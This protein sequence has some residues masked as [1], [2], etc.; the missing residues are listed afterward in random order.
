MATHETVMIMMIIATSFLFGSIL[1]N[2]YI[3]QSITKAIVASGVGKW[4][5]MLFINIFLLVL[6]CFLP[7]VAII[8]IVNPVTH[9][10]ILAYG[11]DPIWFGVVV[12]I[13]MEVGLITPPVGLNLYIVQG[14]APDV[15]LS[16]VLLGSLPFAIILLLGIVIISIWP[17]LALWLPSK[18]IT[19]G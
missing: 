3:T 1:T 2:L 7:P 4:T 10:V 19:R 18:M 9:P 8:L 14:I 15:P 5:L 13:N 11:F 6:G 12:T 17:E 16:K